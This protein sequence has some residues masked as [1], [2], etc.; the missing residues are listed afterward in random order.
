MT[1][2]YKTV[3]VEQVEVDLS[4]SEDTL[5]SLKM[6]SERYGL[7]IDEL[8]KYYIVHAMIQQKEEE[9]KKGKTKQ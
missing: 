7:S 2:K 4:L 6:K 9:L 3:Y 8:I 1:N 5:G